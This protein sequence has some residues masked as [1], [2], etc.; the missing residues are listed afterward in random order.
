MLCAADGEQALALCREH[1][2]DIRLVLLDLTMPGLDGVATYRALKQLR[3]QLGVILCSG[4]SESDAAVRFHGEGLIHFLQK[5][6]EL[7]P[8]RHRIEQLLGERPT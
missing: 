7:Q 6:Y 5:P 1:G 2:D 8:L 3:P 4:Y